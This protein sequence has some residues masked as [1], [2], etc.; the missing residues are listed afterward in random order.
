MVKHWHLVG[1][2]RDVILTFFIGLSP[3]IGFGFAVDKYSFSID[4]GPIWISLEW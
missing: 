1:S 3:R 2:K 4:I